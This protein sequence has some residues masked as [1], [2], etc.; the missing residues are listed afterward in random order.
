MRSLLFLLL[1]LGATTTALLAQTK[2]ID[3]AD[4]ARYGISRRKLMQQYPPAGPDF[5]RRNQKS[6]QDIN[7]QS[8]QQ[9]GAFLRKSK[10]GQ[11]KVGFM[12]TEC[13]ETT[14][15]TTYALIQWFGEVPDTTKQFV[16]RQLEEYYQTRKIEL[17][18]DKRFQINRAFMGGNIPEKRTAR[19][20]PGAIN[21]LEAAQKTTRPDTVK[22]LYFNQLKLAHVPDVV[23][24]F[25]NLT[26]LDLSKNGIK[27]L[28]ARL[29]ADLPKL[30]KLSLLHNSLTND[31]VFFAPNKHLKALNMQGNG[32]TMLPASVRQNRRLESLWLGNNDL[33]T[34]D[35][36]GLRRLND[37]NLYNVGLNEVP[38]SMTKLRQ[39]RVLDLYYNNITK[40]PKRLS[41]LR[42][43]EQLAVSHNKLRE[44][45]EHLAR[46][47]KL[48]ILFAHHNDIGTLPDR[49]E[50]L[51]R[52]RL[53]DLGYNFF[54]T[55]PA[56]LDRIYP[57][58]DLDLSGNNLQELSPGLARLPN[59]K[60]LYLRANPIT[61][62]QPRVSGISQT[63]QQLEARK[64]EVF[65]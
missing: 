39:L 23:Y 22:I 48:Q 26:E 57:L 46:L 19:S 9:F 53:L 30:E 59:L 32:L 60:K 52:L 37:L 50:R 38:P 12:M 47:Q 44:L 21:T 42:H 17:T 36:R 63:I 58:E 24:R 35:F 11:Y 41:R 34:I 29:T 16:M 28:P 49:F 54:S 2:V 20:G 51:R 6:G 27:T 18:A 45:P 25:P 5:A 8:M 61:T 7:T 10:I 3:E 56:V 65:H 33:K 15:E 31:S 55:T 13:F 64:T 62:A 4:T 14:G 1:F 40:L 43:L